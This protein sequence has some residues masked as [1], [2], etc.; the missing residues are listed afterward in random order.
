[1]GHVNKHRLEFETT[2]LEIIL[3]VGGVLAYVAFTFW[4]F[5]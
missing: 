4:A 1:M 3:V 5:T 2:T